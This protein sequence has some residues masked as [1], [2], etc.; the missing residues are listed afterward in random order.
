MRPSTSRGGIARSTASTRRDGVQAWPSTV[1]RA[2]ADEN[3]L[4]SADCQRERRKLA[5]ARK[6]RVP[7]AAHGPEP[8][9]A[10]GLLR[11]PD[12]CRR[13]VADRRLPRLA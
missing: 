7:G 9:L 3:L 13:H 6:V 10:A 8:G 1:L 5:A 2:L 11:L 12:H 4:Q